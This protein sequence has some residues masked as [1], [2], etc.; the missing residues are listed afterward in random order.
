[1]LATLLDRPQGTFA[2]KLTLDGGRVTVTREVDGGLETVSLALPAI[3]T[4]DL[5]LNQPRY[6]SIPNIMKGLR[7]PIA[8]KTIADYGIDP[9]P[10]LKVLNVREPAK[11]RACTRVASAGELVSALRGRREFMA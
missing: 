11:R 7:N 3:V 5:R 8:E 10:R 1:M 6:A 4:T 2:N 9:A